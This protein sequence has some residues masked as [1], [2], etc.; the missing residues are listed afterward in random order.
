MFLTGAGSAFLSIPVLGSLLPR[1]AAAQLG[2]APPLR[3]LMIT[4]E[5]SPN[6]L[7]YFGQLRGPTASLGLQEAPGNA[8]KDRVYVKPLADVAGDISYILPW[9]SG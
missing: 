3:F 7:N 1:K 4:N 8:L 6:E 2:G 9:L 5:Y